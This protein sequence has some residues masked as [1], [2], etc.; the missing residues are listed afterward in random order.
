MG[1]R[2]EGEVPPVWGMD[3]R[4]SSDSMPDSPRMKTVLF[5]GGRDRIC[6]M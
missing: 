3:R 4:A 1:R 6:E 2:N 5:G